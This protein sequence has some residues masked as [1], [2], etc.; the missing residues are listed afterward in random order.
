MQL[1]FE[2]RLEQQLQF[3][4]LQQLVFVRLWFELLRLG[5]LVMEKYVIA[6]SQPSGFTITDYMEIADEADAIET[7][8]VMRHSEGLLPVECRREVHLFKRRELNE[9]IYY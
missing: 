4:G 2:L 9:R 6:L 5:Q 7:A 1:F 8:Q 3:V